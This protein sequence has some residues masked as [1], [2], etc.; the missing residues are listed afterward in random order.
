MRFGDL[1][2][3]V[4]SVAALGKMWGLADEQAT[5]RATTLGLLCLEVGSHKLYPVMQFR[6]KEPRGDVLDVARILK[7]SVG[8]ETISQWL[9][10]P[11]I[12]DAERRTHMQLLDTGELAKV[13]AEAAEAAARWA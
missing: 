12:E 11:C 10:T 5:E 9:M 7:H 1:I 6:G 4:Y 8:A 13:R 2:G 3:S